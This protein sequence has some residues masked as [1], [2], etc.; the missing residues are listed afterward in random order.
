MSFRYPRGMPG[1]HV[2]G[3]GPGDPPLMARRAQDLLTRADAVALDGD[4]PSIV[5]AMADQAARIELAAVGQAGD[6]RVVVLSA[7]PV[8]T[9][10]RLG[11]RVTEVVPSLSAEARR[12]WLESRPLRGARVLVLRPREQALE[13]AAQ[14]A[15][16][17]AQP[18]ICRV[19]SIVDAE[20]R[21]L[22]GVLW[23]LPAAYEWAAFASVHG[24][25]STFRAL[26]RLGKDARAF[27]GVQIGAVGHATAEA[28]AARGVRADVVPEPAT[29]AALGQAMLE[30]DPQLRAGA[31]VLYARAEEGRAELAETLAAGGA[32]VTTVVA[33]RNVPRAAAE[34]AADLMPLR[35]GELDAVLF[36]APSQVALVFAALGAD[37][38]DV[39]GRV[40]TLAAIGP[41]TA[42]AM[43]TRGLRVDVVPEHARVEAVAAALAS[44]YLAR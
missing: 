10:A 44:R 20:P 38:A 1:V 43:T 9:A 31:R 6:A 30:A 24:V 15:D 25:G 32:L 17:G 18:V 27:A 37:A 41:T 28:L 36:F 5:L 35:R 29:G 16:V 13:L 8:A 33:Y 42:E 21:A 39:L 22:D 26:G 3:I 2:V 23:P 7:D 14:L 40:P 12:A 19:S 34:I 4:V 11:A